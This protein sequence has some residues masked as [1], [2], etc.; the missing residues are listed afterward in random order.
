MVIVW[1]FRLIGLGLVFGA[2]VW[3]VYE[4]VYSTLERLR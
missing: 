3:I 1:M 4:L 2:V